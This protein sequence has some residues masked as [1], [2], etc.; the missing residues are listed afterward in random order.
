MTGAQGT[1]ASATAATTSVRSCLDT[2]SPIVSTMKTLFR[3]RSEWLDVSSCSIISGRP[4][5]VI[6]LRNCDNH[7]ATEFF[8]E[9][10]LTNHEFC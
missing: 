3:M 4:K 5:A 2:A 1:P 8:A 9:R 6:S 10:V 7:S